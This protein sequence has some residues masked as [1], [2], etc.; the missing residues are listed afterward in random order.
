MTHLTDFWNNNRMN[1]VDHEE[2][3]RDSTHAIL[4]SPRIKSNCQVS[5]GAR[6]VQLDQTL[7]LSEES[8]ESELDNLC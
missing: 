1:L 8:E 4:S 6:P 7:W 5:S 2:K 3:S